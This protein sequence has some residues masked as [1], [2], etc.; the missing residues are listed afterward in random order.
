MSQAQA[1]AFVRH[2]QA[3]KLSEKR[4]AMTTILYNIYFTMKP[5]VS[6]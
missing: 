6:A 5:I 3:T 4:I 1:G 2:D